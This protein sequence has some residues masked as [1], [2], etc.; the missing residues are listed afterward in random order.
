MA[1]SSRRRG[2]ADGRGVGAAADLCGDVNRSVGWDA[3]EMGL[4]GEPGGSRAAP[5]QGVLWRCCGGW[6]PRSCPVSRRRTGRTAGRD[7]SFVGLEVR[8]L[9]ALQANTLY[10]D[11]NR[12]ALK[13]LDTIANTRVHVR[14]GVMLYERLGQEGLQSM[15]G[16][17][18]TMP[19]SSTHLPGDCFLLH[20]L[21]GGHRCHD[22]RAARQHL[23]VP[24]NQLGIES[25]SHGDVHRVR[26]SETVVLGHLHSAMGKG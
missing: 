15:L 14:T 1:L 8:P 12:Q 5:T 2:G 22:I 21:Q 11:L 3:Q 4:Y 24:G 10:A 17:R 25:L 16:K 26:T 7:Q 19:T 6:R 9:V 20:P 13:W 18:D 23:G